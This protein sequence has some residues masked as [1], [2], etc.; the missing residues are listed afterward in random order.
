MDYKQSSIS[1]EG[2]AFFTELTPFEAVVAVFDR[3]ERT[4][5]L[6]L[7]KSINCPSNKHVIYAG[8]LIETISTIDAFPGTVFLQPPQSLNTPSSM[9]AYFRE[10]E[11]I[12]HTTSL[13]GEYRV[14]YKWESFLESPSDSLAR[15]A[16]EDFSKCCEFAHQLL[17]K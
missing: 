2:S 3:E 4:L 13:M 9:L 16:L 15:R 8:K 5:K 17:Q 12:R 6:Y 11:S 1:T 7:E 10:E 14:C